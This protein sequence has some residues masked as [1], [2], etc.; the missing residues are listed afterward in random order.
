MPPNQCS[1][2]YNEE[3]PLDPFIDPKNFPPDKNWHLS[4]I[5]FTLCVCPHLEMNSS[6]LCVCADACKPVV[7]PHV[8]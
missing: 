2:V 6:C 8:C 7:C 1:A 4:L 5:M 3:I